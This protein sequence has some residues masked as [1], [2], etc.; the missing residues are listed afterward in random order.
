MLLHG[1]IS[2]R[3]IFYFSSTRNGCVW[4]KRDKM[5]GSSLPGTALKRTN[6]PCVPLE[7][8]AVLWGLCCPLS[9][10]Q[11]LVWGV[12]MRNGALGVPPR[13]HREDL[14]MFQILGKVSFQLW[15]AGNVEPRW[16]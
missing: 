9:P 12:E 10:S 4:D 3:K 13:L 2:V 1:L 7:G 16:V 11:E 5:W 14:V 6:I 8:A 15:E